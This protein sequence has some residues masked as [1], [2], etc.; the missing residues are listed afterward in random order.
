MRF[1]YYNPT[2]IVF[3]PGAVQ[4]IG[5]EVARH[6]HKALL[7]VGRSSARQHGLLDRVVRLIQAEGVEV[8]VFEGVEPNPR[9]STVLRGAE[10]ARDKDV[11][12]ALGGGSVMDASKV[13]AAT[14]FYEG[15]PWE[16]F[17]VGARE[18]RLPEKALP[19]ITVPTL[20]A[21]GSEANC[22]AVVTN[23]QTIQK[24]YVSADCLYPKVA[25]VDPELTVTVPKEHTA[26]GIADIISHV[27][28]SYFN[29]VDD[30]PLQDR[31]SE[32]VVSTVL[33]YGPRAVFDGND[34]AARTHLQWASVVAL[35][36][37]VQAGT[38][39]PFPVHGIEHCLSAHYDIPHGA[40]LAI[41]TPAWMRLAA[42]HRPKK[43]AT[44][45][46]RVFG[47]SDS[48]DLAAALA[49][50]DRMEAFLKSIGAPVRLSLVGIPASAILGLA[51][52]AIRVAGNG[53]VLLGRPRLDVEMVAEL[54]RACA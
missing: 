27:T 6:G 1:E 22:G 37:I 16:M 48:D 32:A 33:E 43:F 29:G 35:C 30:T 49:V 40:G 15:D 10:A 39:A 21:T 14:V 36:D 17:Y 7:V 18:V 38:A 52:D 13:M 44:F 50:A 4:N 25:V 46:R 20:A 47:V 53:K 3:G 41:L 12:V 23:E 8:E 2:R 51:S 31:M 9:L 42:R 28:E 26:Y 11:V 24:A 19:V 5:Q 54:L 45:A 34:L